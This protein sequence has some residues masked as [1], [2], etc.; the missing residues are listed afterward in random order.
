M[1]HHLLVIFLALDPAEIVVT[2][3]RL[4]EIGAIAKEPT[5]G[6]GHEPMTIQTQKICSEREMLLQK[7]L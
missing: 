5:G 6:Y 7:N 2:E 4:L 1:I 3:T